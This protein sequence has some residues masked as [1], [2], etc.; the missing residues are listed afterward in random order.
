MNNYLIN[1]F[2]LLRDPFFGLFEGFSKSDVLRSDIKESKDD[3]IIEVE[4][5]GFN[6]SDI[7]LSLEDKYLTVLASKDS[8]VEDGV[9]YIHKER[10][11]GTYKRSFFVGDVS[12]EEVKANINDGI[13]TIKIA[14]DSFNKKEKAKFIEIN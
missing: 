7:K 6:K 8:K 5:S 9:K 1:E 13:L 4:V 12:I 14:K 2:D 11:S 3:Y 10:V